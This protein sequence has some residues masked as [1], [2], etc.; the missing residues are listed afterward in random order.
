MDKSRA[1]ALANEMNQ[2]LTQLLVAGN[3]GMV[4]ARER[5]LSGGEVLTARVALVRCAV[6]GKQFCGSGQ[7]VGCGLCECCPRVTGRGGSAEAGRCAFPF[8]IFCSHTCVFQEI[9]AL[10]VDLDLKNALKQKHVANMQDWE[11][12]FQPKDST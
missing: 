1:V 10:T 6:V 8:V 4:R 12:K 11:Q 9:A 2:N 3:P 7:R 5:C